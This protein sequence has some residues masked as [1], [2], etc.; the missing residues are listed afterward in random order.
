MRAD[1][2]NCL[3]FED[4]PAGIVA[5]RAAGMYVVAVPD[6]HMDHG[7]YRGAHEIL[8]SLEEFDPSRW[9]FTQS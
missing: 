4:S 7:V 2:E 1:P 8:R 5:A 3:V 9:G 6:P